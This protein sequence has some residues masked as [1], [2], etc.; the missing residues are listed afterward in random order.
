MLIKKG[1]VTFSQLQCSME[2]KGD[3]FH[4]AKGDNLQ[5]FVSCSNS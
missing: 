2:L 5:L 4:I 1:Q 3:N